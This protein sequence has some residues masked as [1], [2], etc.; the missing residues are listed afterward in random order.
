VSIIFIDLFPPIDNYYQLDVIY[1]KLHQL[2]IFAIQRGIKMPQIN[3]TPFIRNTQSKDKPEF[4]Y[5]QFLNL[6]SLYKCIRYA[7]AF[8]ITRASLIGS[9]PFGIAFFASNYQASP[10]SL[11]LGLFSVL[12]LLTTSASF[13]DILKYMLVMLLFSLSARLINLDTFLKKGIS[14]CFCV[15]LS[16]TV[17]FIKKPVLIYD[18]SLLLAEA[19]LSFI[20][21]IAISK[22]MPIL[23][24]SKLRRQIATED[25]ISVSIFLGLLILGTSDF[26]KFHNL[27]ITNSLCILVILIF[28]YKFGPTTS[29]AAGVCMGLIA[30]GAN[31]TLAS[32][33]G[34]YAFSSMFCGLFRKI[35][36]LSVACSFILSNSLITM[37]SNSSSEVF[38]NIYDIFLA[39]SIFLLIPGITL[40]KLFDKS[41]ESTKNMLSAR[42][43]ESESMRVSA[44]SQ[45]FL[46]LKESFLSLKDIKTNNITKRT[47]QILERTANRVCGSCTFKTHCWENDFNNTYS[48]AIKILDALEK[49]ENISHLDFSKCAKRAL[50]LENLARCYEI[51]LLDLKW[52]SR[53]EELQGVVATQLDC[54]SKVLKS[55]AK[56]I[57]R[58]ATFDF[59]LELLLKKAFEKENLIPLSL[60]VINLP[61]GELEITL[62]LKGCPGFL[63]CDTKIKNIIKEVVGQK[64]ERV[65]DKNCANCHLKYV[66]VPKNRV[67]SYSLSEPK[68]NYAYCGDIFKKVRLSSHKF[69]L[70]LCDGM[71]SGK[72]AQDESG[73]IANL[74][75]SLLEYGFDGENALGFA[76]TLLL[77]K[78]TEQS[79]LSVD[80]CVVDTSS[81]EAEFI[82]N[83]GAASFVVG[84]EE[85]KIINSKSMPLG[86]TPSADITSTKIKLNE[87]DLIIMVSDGVLDANTK[88]VNK[89][90]WLV[91]LIKSEDK[92]EPETL[93]KSIIRKVK[94]QSGTIRDDMTVAVTY[95]PMFAG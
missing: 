74:I 33:L 62:R 1:S 53:F 31:Y 54:V 88:D 12:G 6:F 73:A 75:A 89:E 87:D 25:A 93:C 11:I 19:S 5:K 68:Q 92:K 50:F 94:D 49:G 15:L 76:N 56:E 84:K 47:T 57:K 32:V 14:L 16:G 48:Q 51:N 2:F 28:A 21:L 10:F 82:K 45:A 77:M 86:I 41:E 42:I 24:D 13:L 26:L 18:I 34:S 22:A 64:V 59:K 3:V 35:N 70:I 81:G 27:S 52:Q 44:Y 46:T 23:E 8:I 90:Q 85:V 58:Y 37:V 78:S 36:R 39:S 65:G 95:F 40:D 63:E 91:E 29:A 61:D 66:T 20:S 80:L 72:K 83:G 9:F 55:A 7:T 67:Q 17:F 79:L 30:S 43:R 71:G 4:S 60:N 69:A 38:I